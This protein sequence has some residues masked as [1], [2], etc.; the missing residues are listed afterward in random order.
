MSV[1]Y[2]SELATTHANRGCKVIPELKVEMAALGEKYGFSNCEGGSQIVRGAQIG[3]VF[4]ST[5]ASVA[6]FIQNIKFQ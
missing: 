4:F 5:H 6:G 1:A 3:E 2:R